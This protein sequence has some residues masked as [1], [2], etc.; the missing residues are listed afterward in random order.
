M[1]Q[2]WSKTKSFQVHVSKALYQ[3]VSM[4]YETVQMGQVTDSFEKVQ[5]QN[6]FNVKVNKGSGD[7]S[8]W[9]MIKYNIYAYIKAL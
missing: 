9:N 6:K 4:F 8:A 7:M 5:V 1:S 3:D 2:K